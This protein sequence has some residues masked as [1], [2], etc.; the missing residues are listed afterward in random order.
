MSNYFHVAMV[1]T[2]SE[3]NLLLYLDLFSVMFS[4]QL[5]FIASLCPTVLTLHWQSSSELNMSELMKKGAV[6]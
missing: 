3:I 5:A 6:K 1:T 2:C 4:R